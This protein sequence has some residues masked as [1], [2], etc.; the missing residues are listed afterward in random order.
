MSEADLA[1]HQTQHDTLQT[2]QLDVCG[3]QTGDTFGYRYH[4]S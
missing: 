3:G 4:T 1:Y 2:G